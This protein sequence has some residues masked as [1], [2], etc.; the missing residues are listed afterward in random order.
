MNPSYKRGR[1]AGMT[2][3]EA[4][5]FYPELFARKPYRSPTLRFLGKLSDLTSGGAGTVDDMM[6]GRQ[7]G[8][9]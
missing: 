1:E 6:G 8:S 5:T 2:E 7:P 9:P 4:R 3:L